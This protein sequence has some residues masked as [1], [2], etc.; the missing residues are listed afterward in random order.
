MEP[1]LFALAV[2]LIIVFVVAHAIA[3]L[4]WLF[5]LTKKASDN[6]SHDVL[7]LDYTYDD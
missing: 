1:L 4:V 6:L 7:D 2:I 5:R 3:G